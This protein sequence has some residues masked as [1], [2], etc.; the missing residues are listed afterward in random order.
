MSGRARS[1]LGW[2]A[3]IG[4]G[5]LALALLV[6]LGWL[7]AAALIRSR[8][9][10]G[11]RDWE[12][13]MRAAGWTIDH[14]PVR[15]AGLFEGAVM[16]PAVRLAGGGAAVPGGIVWQAALARLGWS[17]LRPSL[18][19]V[20]GQG[21]E[22]LAVARLPTLHADGPIRAVIDLGDA[23]APV[24]MTAGA[25]ALSDGGARFSVAGGS[26]MLMPHPGAA[27]GQPLL[28]VSLT[29]QGLTAAS[30][31]ALP[32]DLEAA[33]MVSGPAPPPGLALAEQ[34]RAWQAAGGT[35]TIPRLDA[36]SGPMAVVASGSGSLDAALQPVAQASLRLTG[37]DA[38]VDQLADIGAL[39]RGQSIAL[40][41]V[42]G[43]LERTPADG[44]PAVVTLP[45]QWQDGRVSV[46]GFT[47]ARSKP[48]TW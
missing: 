26:L 19:G 14:A 7:G 38:L 32:V 12:R 15:A 16:V 45:M 21:A 20:D 34:A 30:A 6:G 22:S 42:I 24:P 33:G 44:G 41:A 28:S 4:L 10:A 8:L 43:L 31:P 5:L 37:A 35:V 36:Q 46:G 1:E 29:A 11:L 2:G 27:A 40:G 18:L 13:D 23:R 47:L 3:R 25:L 9:E 17:P 39:G 48:L